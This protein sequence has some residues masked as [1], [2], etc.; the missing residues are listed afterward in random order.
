MTLA[1]HANGEWE[2]WPSIEGLVAATGF[3]DTPV[4]L[5]LKHLEKE[6]YLTRARERLKDG[7]LGRY[8]YRLNHLRMA[9][10]GLQLVP[11]AEEKHQR[12]HGP[13]PNTGGHENSPE[14]MDRCET[15][16]DEPPSPDTGRTTGARHRSTKP[17]L[18]SNRQDASLPSNEGTEDASGDL[19]EAHPRP[20]SEPELL[21]HTVYT[22]GK[23][24]LGRDGLSPAQAGAF[25]GKQ[26]KA[27]SLKIVA[28]VIS[29]AAQ[30]PPVDARGWI[31][32]AVIAEARKAGIPRTSRNTDPIDWPATLA[33][34]FD[35]GTWPRRAGPPPTDR[36]FAGPI[37]ELAALL[38]RF[39]AGH[40]TA[41][42]I[43][44]VIEAHSRAKTGATHV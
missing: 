30:N 40:P 44:R 24:L 36:D 8:Q 5:A 17:S 34:W 28:R 42:D 14:N 21:R 26:I 6:G 38:P 32:A 1:N 41:R 37:A 31:S 4:R 10:G 18:D 23:P 27:S 16:V 19:F 2:C 3:K 35:T 33:T 13:V 15:P 9:S 12:N 43:S 7:S 29:Q 39:D 25:L 22:L 11:K 20:M